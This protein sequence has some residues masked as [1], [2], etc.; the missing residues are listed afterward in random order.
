MADA[1]LRN[2]DHRPYPP[3]ESPWVI[4]MSWH[5]LLFMHWPVPERKLRPLIPPAL[6]LDT[7]DNNAWL[8]VV[9]FRMSGVRPRLLPDMPGLSAFPELNVRTYV[10]A[11]DRPGVWFFS[12]DAHNRPAVRLARALFR[13]PYFDAE[14]SCEPAGGEVRYRSVRTHRGAPPARFAAR[15]RPLRKLPESRPGTLEHF[16]TERYCLYASE[17]G[18]RPLRAEIH[19]EAW[20]LRHA[21]A[22]V[23]TLEMTGQIGVELPDTA[24]VLHFAQRLDVVAWLPRRVKS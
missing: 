16:L 11:G 2:T 23:E 24:P 4:R 17:P 5:D 10:T 21:E 13:L 14:M 1:A 3:P 20:P 19:H 22:E 7:F 15:Y 6:K 18:G 9:P 12:L 8:G